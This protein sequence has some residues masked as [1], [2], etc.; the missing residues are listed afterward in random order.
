MHLNDYN[1]FLLGNYTGGHD[2]VG[3]VAAA[4]DITLENFA[5]GSGLA[6]DDTANV[7]V[8]GANLS[9]DRGAVYGD[10][11]YGGAYSTNPSV[12]SRGAAVPGPARS[13]SPPGSPR[14]AVC[15]RSWPAC[16]PTAP[17]PATTGV[18]SS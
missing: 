10:A 11:H 1:L 6:A 9:L 8:A 15:P 3:K 13:T 16:P 14:C 18:A 17:P 12:T 7:L 2:V 4:G 5:V